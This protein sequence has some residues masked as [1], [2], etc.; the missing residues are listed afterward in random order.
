MDASSNPNSSQ[1]AA[2]ALQSGAFC[3]STVAAILANQ[4]GLP[5]IWVVAS[6]ALGFFGGAVCGWAVGVGLVP[7]A[8][9]LVPSG[10]SQTLLVSA[11]SASGTAALTLGI[12]MLIAP[13]FGSVIVA[14][15]VA[16][17]VAL[18]FGFPGTGP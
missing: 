18:V 12:F 11:S 2:L 8:Q 10:R 16:T 13:A 7:L 14:A 4:A 15:G 6:L 5:G 17:T 9:S 3:G 1:L